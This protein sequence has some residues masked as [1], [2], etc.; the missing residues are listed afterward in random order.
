VE[1]SPS[2]PCRDPMCEPGLLA[3]LAERFLERDEVGLDLDDEDRAT[4][5]VPSQQVDRASLAVDRA[6]H[7]RP[8]EPAE[9]LEHP[10]GPSDELSVA[11]I[12]QAIEVAAA[13]LDR[14]ADLCIQ[15]G[16]DAS[17]LG[18]RHAS[19]VAALE[20]G[21]EVLRHSSPCRHV[22]LPPAKSVAD[23]PKRP[24]DPRILHPSIFVVRTYRVVIY[25]SRA[26]K[27]RLVSSQASGSGFVSAL[28]ASAG[29]PQAAARA[30]HAATTHP[31][32][33]R[34]RFLTAPPPPR[35]RC[36][37]GVPRDLATRYD[38]PGA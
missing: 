14:Q 2:V 35:T 15:R 8:D 32:R 24:A 9:R 13:P 27:A 26:S 7:L 28:G 22:R 16:R 23:R 11:F 31:M 18:D 30:R 19:E 38:A 34:W 10:C 25:A 5:R 21:H 6:G 20:P 3:V 17:D 37:D 36:V 29:E 12:D 4:C 33:I 1:P